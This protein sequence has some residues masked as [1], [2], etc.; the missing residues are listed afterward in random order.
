ME[1]HFIKVS[2]KKV[3]V[4]RSET[5]VL[6][7]NVSGKNCPVDSGYY[8]RRACDDCRLFVIENLSEFCAMVLKCQSP[9]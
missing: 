4:R 2:I 5:K 8:S 6:V 7:P 1:L 9:L 3:R